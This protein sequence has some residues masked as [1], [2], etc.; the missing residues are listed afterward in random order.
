M[1]ARRHITQKKKIKAG[2]QRAACA[3]DVRAGEMV[4]LR[5]ERPE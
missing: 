5:L 1:Y 4:P 3:A 2:E